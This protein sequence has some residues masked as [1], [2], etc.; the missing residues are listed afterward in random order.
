MALFIEMTDRLAPPPPA[1]GGGVM[2]ESVLAS[3][4]CCGQAVFCVSAHPVVKVEASGKSAEVFQRAFSLSVH[5]ESGY[6]YMRPV[7]RLGK[8]SLEVIEHLSVFG[9]CFAAKTN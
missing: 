6:L 2:A 8:Y 3:F 5:F 1:W 7:S 4:S 9:R